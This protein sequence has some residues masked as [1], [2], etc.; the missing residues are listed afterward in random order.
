MNWKRGFKRITNVLAIVT[1]IAFGCIAGLEAYNEYDDAHITSSHFRLW[2]LENDLAKAE[3][4]N[5]II[6][7]MG[8]SP[9][10][11]CYNEMIAD[12]DSNSLDF[13][14]QQDI[15]KCKEA[16][17]NERKKIEVL[18]K[19]RKTSFWYNLSIAKLVGMVVLYGLGGAVAG[20]V[21]TWVVLWYGSLIVFMFLRWLALGFRE[22]KQKQ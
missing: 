17:E 11:Q 6:D 4:F 3:E 14:V 16:I 10:A 2:Q 22:D 5:R 19:E 13:P 9:A 12:R 20:Y 1:A 18:E 21:G 8:T 7:K 15:L